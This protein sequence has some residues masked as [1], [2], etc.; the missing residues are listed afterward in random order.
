[1]EI[2]KPDSLK[3]QKQGRGKGE[4][5]IT[6]FFYDLWSA[7]DGKSVFSQPFLSSLPYF[8]IPEIKHTYSSMHY[9]A[10]FL[11][12]MKHFLKS[13]LCLL[14]HIICK[15]KQSKDSSVSEKGMQRQ[16]TFCKAQ[17]ACAEPGCWICVPQ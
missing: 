14:P 10:R 8:S 15:S 7:G 4:R 13:D 5:T 3:R 12:K 1:M 6:A 11:S 17:A 9:F 2:P 16:S